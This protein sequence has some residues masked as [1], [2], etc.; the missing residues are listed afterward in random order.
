MYN[1]GMAED[2]KQ[3]HIKA[4]QSLADR[5]NAYAS[6]TRR[7]NQSGILF[8]IEQGLESEKARGNYQEPELYIK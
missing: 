5:I 1:W 6:Q 8:L 3:F 4:D 7:S 2:K